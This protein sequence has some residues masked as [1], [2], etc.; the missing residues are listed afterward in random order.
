[1]YNNEL[2]AGRQFLYG[3][4]SVGTCCSCGG[5]LRDA[6]PLGKSLKSSFT[7]FDAFV[8]GS[9]TMVCFGCRY[10]LEVKP[11]RFNTIF[12]QRPGEIETKRNSE[13]YEKIIK[14]PEKF[15][16]SLSRSHKKHHWLYAGLSTPEKIFFGTDLQTILYEPQKHKVVFDTIIEMILHN[17]PVTQIISGRYHP[18]TY[19]KVGADWLAMADAKI[20]THRATGLVDLLVQI[21]PRPEK[22]DLIPKEDF[23]TMIDPLDRQAAEYLAVIALHSSYRRER[24]KDFWDGFFLYRVNRVSRLPLAEATNKLLSL[25]MVPATAAGEWVIPQLEKLSAEQQIEIE[26][27]IRERSKLIVA[28]AY[29]I[30]KENKNTKEGIF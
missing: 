6:L 12:C 22:K 30:L 8:L 24:G 19:M 17:V 16:V 15:V 25:L 26:A 11:L 14:P 29:S 27:A 28:L 23:F 4:I 9:G 2:Q 18:A 5:E 13:L 10:L 20:K 7:T 3:Q 21:S 1:M